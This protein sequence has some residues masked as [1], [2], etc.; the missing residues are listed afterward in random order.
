ML[1]LPLSVKLALKYL[2]S[3][4]AESPTKISIKNQRALEIFKI[5]STDLKWAGT[6]IQDKI[7]FLFFN[8]Q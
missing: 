2:L 1:R 8:Q 4:R 7:R 3:L 6:D 5:G